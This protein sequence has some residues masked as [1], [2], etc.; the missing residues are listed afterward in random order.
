MAQRCDICGK[1]PQVGC[2]VSHSK[3]RTKRRWLPNLR[4][5]RIVRDSRTVHANVCTGCI[6]AGKVKRPA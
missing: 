5:I 1:G 6:S 3:R 4:R 2:S